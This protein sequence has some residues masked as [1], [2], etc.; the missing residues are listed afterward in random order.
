MRASSVSI[1]GVQGLRGS[2]PANF[3]Y[4]HVEFGL[5]AGFVHVID[6]E[7]AFDAA[8]ARNVLAGLLQ[9]AV[10][11][12][13]MSASRQGHVAHQSEAERFLASYAEHDWTKALH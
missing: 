4:L 8:F 10:E 2:I 11:D 5:A 6:D 1:N 3:P 9:S 7:A 12:Q 13:R